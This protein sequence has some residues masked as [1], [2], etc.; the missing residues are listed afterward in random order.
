MSERKKLS[1]E[2]ENFISDYR[3][4]KILIPLI[5]SKINIFV[6]N[7]FCEKNLEN[8]GKLISTL[9]SFSNKFYFF[10]NILKIV[11]SNLDKDLT[12][13]NNLG[14]T[15]KNKN[16]HFL[17]SEFLSDFSQ[18]LNLLHVGDLFLILYSFY[19]NVVSGGAGDNNPDKKI[20]SKLNLKCIQCE[21]EF[22]FNLTAGNLFYSENFLKIPKCGSAFC[23]KK[24]EEKFEKKIKDKKI[25]FIFK[26]PSIGDFIKNEL[27]IFKK[28][29]KSDE[30]IF[31]AENLFFHFLRVIKISSQNSE[32]INLV[33]YSEIKEFV[34]KLPAKFY[35]ELFSFYRT[36]VYEK[37]FPQFKIPISCPYC[38]AVNERE[39]D[40]SS[41][42]DGKVWS[43][44][45][46]SE[47]TDYVQKF[48]ELHINSKLNYSGLED[49]FKLPRAAVKI[50]IEIDKEIIENE[51]KEYERELKKIEQQQKR[52]KI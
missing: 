48:V 25:E 3:P 26:I 47:I 40:I 33:N 30:N 12:V 50:P 29:K 11:F 28:E 31:S 23:Y 51:R 9:N 45:L 21:K 4:S 38:G 43:Y 16:S 1:I 41:H 13:F 8:L 6:D 5:F 35:S 44:D 20:I 22:G 24:I 19:F 2:L 27:F 14:V 7:P 10:Q 49:L 34:D 15:V 36:N 42:I 32:E 37:Y 39:I 17:F 52:H 18:F 46:M